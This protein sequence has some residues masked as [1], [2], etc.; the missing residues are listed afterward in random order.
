MKN[1]ILEL[2]EKMGVK[3]FSRRLKNTPILWNWVNEQ[4]IDM[5]PNTSISE[6]T[7]CALNNVRPLCNISN[8][9]RTFWSIEGGYGHCG[10]ASSCECVRQQVSDGVSKSKQSLTNDEKEEINKKRVATTLK[11]H[12]VTNNFQT[13][14][15]RANH[16]LFYE[17]E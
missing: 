1:Q 13:F 4:T 5:T 6:R 3:H 9:N 10:K 2:I 16:T 14:T 8:K 11:L 17:D 12:G 15:A 7:Y